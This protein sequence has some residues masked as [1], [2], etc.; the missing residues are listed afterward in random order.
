M[1]C[2]IVR[3]VCKTEGETKPW[4]FDYAGYDAN[5]GTW[6]FLVRVWAPGYVYGLD[7]TVRPSSPTGLQYTATAGQSGAREPRWPD[8]VGGTVSDGSVTW[9]AEA[10]G[11]D[12]LLTTIASSSWQ[13]FDSSLAVSD[14]LLV[15]T[16]GAQV[17]TVQVSGGVMGSDYEVL[18]TITLEDGSV[19]ESRLLV[20]V[21]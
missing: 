10:I 7:E 18:N 11:N 2:R 6:G 5:S 20:Q 21:R 8:T 19:E 3:K 14:E 4:G 9:T 12:S 17:A 16:G 15:N 1:T 13:S